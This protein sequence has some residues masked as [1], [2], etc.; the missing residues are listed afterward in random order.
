MSTIID[1]IP[2][3]HVG[4]LTSCILHQDFL[5]L[6]KTLCLVKQA[7]KK[8]CIKLNYCLYII[9]CNPYNVLGIVAQYIAGKSALL[10][11]KKTN[12]QPKIKGEING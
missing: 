7:H 10:P 6:C 9:P 5:N 8:D 4:S 11:M 2:E 3:Y 1:Y 12:N